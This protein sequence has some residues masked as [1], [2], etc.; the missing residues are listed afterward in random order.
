[1]RVLTA[2]LVLVFV[3]GSLGGA[4]STTDPAKSASGKKPSTV[5]TV[6]TGQHFGYMND[7]LYLKLDDG[8]K[9]TL[10]VDIPGDKDGKWRKDHR[11]MSRIT[12]TYHVKPGGELVATS[13]KKADEPT[14]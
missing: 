12:V 13:I 9:L 6:V 3:G 2:V 8:K 14:K 10:T 5:D 4:Q 7:E 11:T 1:M